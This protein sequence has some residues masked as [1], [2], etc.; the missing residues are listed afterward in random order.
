MKRK[1]KDSLFAASPIL[2]RYLGCA[3]MYATLT[4]SIVVSPLERFPPSVISPAHM[5]TGYV[6]GD[7]DDRILAF[8]VRTLIIHAHLISGLTIANVTLYLCI[9][10]F[11][12]AASGS[13][14]R[15]RGAALS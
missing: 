11:F 7:F 14:I 10:F 15:V 3:A 5:R 13:I 6:P 12:A 8:V 1:E 9:F 2:G 4:C